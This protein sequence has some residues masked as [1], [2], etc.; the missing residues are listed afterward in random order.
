MRG[1]V[2]VGV[3]QGKRNI[4]KKREV[5]ILLR[6]AFLFL[7]FWQLEESVSCPVDCRIN[8]NIV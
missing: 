4:V 7:N 8:Q 6:E 5:S 1:G 2:K 3:V